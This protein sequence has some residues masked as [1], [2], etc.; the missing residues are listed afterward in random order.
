MSVLPG[1]YRT[2]VEHAPDAMALVKMD[3]GR[4][5]IANAALGRVLGFDVWELVGEVWS[6]RI[7]PDDVDVAMADRVGLELGSIEVVRNEYRLIDAQA[8]GSRC[9]VT[10]HGVRLDGAGYLAHYVK[11]A[12]R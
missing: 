4:I 3:D 7:H 1:G 11:P 10:T 2:L 6:D 9:V 12:R 5:Q 8:R